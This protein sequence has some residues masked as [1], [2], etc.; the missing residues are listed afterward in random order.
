MSRVFADRIYGW[1]STTLDPN[2]GPQAP[3]VPLEAGPSPLA[4][5]DAGHGLLAP[6]DAGHNTLAPLN[7][8]HGQLAARGSSARGSIAVRAT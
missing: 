7:A 6:L 3:A 4:P 8:G 2:T 5:L 1:V